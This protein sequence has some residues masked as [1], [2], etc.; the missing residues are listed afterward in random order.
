[1]ANRRAAG[2]EGSRCLQRVPTVEGPR[3]H[4]D[5]NLMDTSFS[6]ILVA[7]FAI[8]NPI[9]NA[10][11][12]VGLTQGM[13]TGTR[14]R[15]AIQGVLLAF[16]I[17]AVFALCGDLIFEMF[18]ITLPAFRIAGGVLVALVGYNLLHGLASSVH[19]PSDADRLQDGQAALGIAISPLAMPLLAGPGTIATAMS[20][21]ASNV[22]PQD[23]TAAADAIASGHKFLQIGEVL[24]AFGI[25][26]LVTLIA[27]LGGESMVRFLGQNV[28]HVLTRLMGLILAVVG[29]QMLIEGIKVAFGLG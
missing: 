21:A 17:V 10:P 1:M 12:F 26:C 27:F 7:F 29:V 9:A 8:M 23:T 16:G 4:T 14:R 25:V 19:T 11:V 13:P 5:G 22:R 28:I 6:H 2:A 24:G 18:G 3:C 15:I 20:F